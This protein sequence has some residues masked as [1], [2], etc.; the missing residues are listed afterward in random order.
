VEFVTREAMQIHGGY[1][2]S[3]EFDVQRYWRDA[4]VF[5]LFEGT[6]E[7]QREVIGRSL[8]GRGDG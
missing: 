4:K 1:G 7:I 3:K 2:Y 5:S 8:A 6:S